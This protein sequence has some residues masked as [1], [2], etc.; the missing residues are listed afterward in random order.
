MHVRPATPADF[1]AIL[2]LNEESLAYLSPLSA[3]RLADLHA[4]AAVH[5]V[6]E[7]NATVIAFILALREGAAY[8]SQNYLWFAQRYTEFLYVDRIVVSM[9]ARKSGAG[10]LLYR[11][12]FAFAASTA[13]PLVTCEYDVEPPNPSS[14]RFH[15]RFGFREV[16]RQ[17][18]AGGTKVVSLQV[19]T[20]ER[21]GN[22]P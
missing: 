15:S 1:E 3:S 5:R 17:T 9:R 16:G 19:A 10:S 21:V 18:V 22:Q 20:I 8:D 2:A 6:V 14:A 13:V 4:E 7:D 11:D 12:L